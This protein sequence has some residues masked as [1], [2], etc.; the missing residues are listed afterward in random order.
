[1][2][3]ETAAPTGSN[4]EE[5]EAGVIG[6]LMN[7]VVF[8]FPFEGSDSELFSD[9]SSSGSWVTLIEFLENMP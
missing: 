4:A 6:D 7:D 3:L 2:Q 9:T 1:M 8:D 5:I